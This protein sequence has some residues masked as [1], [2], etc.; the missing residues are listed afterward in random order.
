MSQDTNDTIGLSRR[1]VLA[2]LGAVGVAS[3]GAGLGT[4][5]YFNDTESF[6]GNTL[7]AG[8][9]DLK[10]DYKSTYLGG[11]GR[12]EH[13]QSMGYPDAEELGDGRYLLDQAP[14]PADMQ[15]WEDLVMEEDGFDFCS[16]EADQYLV[17]GDG[18]PVFTLDDVKPG[19]SGE[20]T[21]SIHICDNPAF[22]YLAGELSQAENG[23]SEPEADEDDTPGQGDLADAIE[24][25]VWYDEDCD[26][27]YEPTGT[28]Q[29]QELEVA[30]VSDVSGSMG[31]APLSA[32]KTAA[33][34][35]VGNLSSPDEA[36][37]ISFNSG[38]STDQELT[39]NYQAVQNAIN[40]YTAGGGTS[41]AA[42]I[43]EG[44]NELLNGT[45]ATPGASK[46]MI[47]LSD[48]QSD[49]TAAINAANDAKN[50]GI[51][52]FTIALGNAD[53]GLLESVASSP[54]DAFVA[55]DP[56][57][58]DTVYAEIAQI[59]LAGEQKILSGTMSEVFAELA[60]GEALDGDRQ[61]EGR[62]PYPGATTQCIGFEWTLPAEVGNEIQ[63]D[64][65]SFDLA[66]YAEQSRHN[67]NPQ[68]AFNGTDV[69]STSP[70]PAPN[71]TGNVSGQ[72]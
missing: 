29:Q 42:G 37:A 31:G 5:A 55:P 23:Q 61:V 12:L 20:V 50:N 58:L 22:L 11:P 17:N 36:A 43:I 7:T 19:D 27:V 41:I 40:N 67:D 68:V 39:T 14:S 64:S 2:G 48:G 66:V 38:A 45:I 4:T 15:A 35:F 28:G 25:C 44:E 69:N 6:E 57:D 24:V 51:R 56:S 60:D 3:A 72:N 1:K 59:V 34:S 33:T 9:L 63:T 18:I 10:L 52:I 49:D 8:E 32:L 16:P 65:V 70:G 54:D 46:V 62:Q 13:V 21:I 71:G 53:T 30:L 47:L 26:N